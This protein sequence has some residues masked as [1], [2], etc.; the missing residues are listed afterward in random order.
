MKIRLN[1]IKLTLTMVSKFKE[2]QLIGIEIK[3]SLARF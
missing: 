3:Y 1:Y 2:A